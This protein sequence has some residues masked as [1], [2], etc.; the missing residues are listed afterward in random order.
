MSLDRQKHVGESFIEME[1]GKA[2]GLSGLVSEMVKSAREAVGTIT[3]KLS[4]IIVGYFSL[5]WERSTIANCYK[6]KGVRLERGKYSEL[7]EL[8]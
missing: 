4:Q 1:N 2:A 7:I 5:E 8:K 6:E 3:A